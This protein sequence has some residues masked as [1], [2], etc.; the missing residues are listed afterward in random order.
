MDVLTMILIY[1]AVDILLFVVGLILMVRNIRPIL[2]F[3]M[4]ALSLV[5][6]IA[7]F[8]YHKSPLYVYR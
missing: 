5:M 3:F 7:L 4:I 6:V 2:G 1:A 8:L